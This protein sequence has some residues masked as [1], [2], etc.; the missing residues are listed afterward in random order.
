MAITIGTFVLL[1]HSIA[2][3]VATG[4]EPNTDPIS[5]YWDCCKPACSSSD[6]PEHNIF[7]TCDATGQSPGVY[8]LGKSVCHSNVST[9]KSWCPT[10]YKNPAHNAEC[11]KRVPFVH[12]NELYSYASYTEPKGTTTSHQ[13]CGACRTLTLHTSSRNSNDTVRYAHIKY[14]NSKPYPA[15]PGSH[16]M[17]GYRLLVPGAGLG[18]Y[19]SGCACTFPDMYT[20]EICGA[21]GTEDSDNCKQFGGMQTLTGCEALRDDTA[22]TACK[23]VKLGILNNG[24]YVRDHSHITVLE[25]APA[26]CS[27]FDEVMAKARSSH[28]RRNA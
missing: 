8:H 23:D 12:E 22:V 28:T 21:S 2:E 15:K 26:D 7:Q 6:S 24:A 19:S 18:D 10:A 14:V 16:S 25:D 4:P 3:Q 9:V 17:T 5:G 11:L 27:R 13:F 20:P 1:T